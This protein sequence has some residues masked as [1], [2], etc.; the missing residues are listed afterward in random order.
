MKS[1]YKS[2]SF[3]LSYLF[4]ITRAIAQVPSNY[5]QAAEGKSK[6]ELKT[7]LHEII[8]P[9]T[10]LEYYGSRYSFRSTDWHPDGH[11]WD[12]YSNIKRSSWTGLNR[13]HNM[14]KSW[15]STNPETTV[16]Y[17]DLH[18]LYPSDKNA[19]SA[20]LNYPLGLVSGSGTFSNGLVKVGTS[21]YPGYTGNVFEPADEYK[22]D[23]ARDYMYMVTCYE[24]YAYNWRSLGTASMLTNGT[25]PV[26][27]PYAI[28]LLMQW[29]ADD[30]VSPKETNRN[31]AVYSLQ[32]NRN[33]F[34][35]F[36]VLADYIWGKFVDSEWKG[37]NDQPKAFRIRYNKADNSLTVDILHPEQA[38][39][40]IFSA[41]GVMVKKGNPTTDSKIVLDG[42]SKGLYIIVVYYDGKRQAE[43]F[44]LGES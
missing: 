32:N 31:D 26:F 5:Y 36:P 24:D 30:P 27:K 40:Q 12:M 9:H 19:N 11:Y 22:G 41:S 39:Y 7:A 38:Q 21:A 33:P 17:T 28:S 44:I 20:K 3:F 25:Y 2:F 43:K 29:H 42:I 8:K 4:L 16:A 37:G 35:D 13:E 18:N 10:V 1:F 23:F 34:I 15:W 14:P 6:A